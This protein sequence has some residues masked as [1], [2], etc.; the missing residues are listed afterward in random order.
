MVNVHD[1][2]VSGLI[3]M[4]EFRPRHMYFTYRL[5]SPCFYLQYSDYKDGFESGACSELG[6]VSNKT[7]PVTDLL[8][9]LPPCLLHTLQVII[10]CEKL[11]TLWCI[12]SLEGC[13]YTHTGV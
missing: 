5:K 7:L 8:L 6:T 4:G 3:S 2:S 9:D 10:L 12:D 11:H 1:N 13:I